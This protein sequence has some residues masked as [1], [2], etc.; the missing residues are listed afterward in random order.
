MQ[1]NKTRIVV[2]GMGAVTPL[3]VGVENFWQNLLAGKSGIGP[4]TRYDTTDMPA[5]MAAEIHDF[6]PTEHGIP[7][8]IA[9]R[10]A[11]VTQYAYAAVGEALA[12][13]GYEVDPMRTGIVLGTALTSTQD[14]AEG[15]NTFVA[16]GSKKASPHFVPKILPSIAACQVAIGFNLRG[17]N[18]TLSN[19]CASGDDAVGLAAML[20]R[21]GAADAIVA[22]G[23]EAVTCPVVVSSLAASRVLITGDDPTAC[24]PFDKD[25]AGFVLGE[26]GGALVLE[27][28][29]H[30]KARGAKI[31][32]VLL[33]H[34][35]NNDAFHITTP[36]DGGE[37]GADCIRLALEDAGL[38]PGDIDYINSHGTGTKLG[39][40]LECAAVRSVFGDELLKEIPMNSLRGATGHMMAAGSITDSI[41][42]LLAMRDG[43]IPPTLNFETPDPD[44]PIDCVPN[45]ARK[46]ELN[47]VMNNAFGFGGQNASLIFGKYH[48]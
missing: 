3:G 4:I 47:I 10:M 28:E 27:T 12:D 32:G 25:R 19:A 6:D 26:G 29:E 13:S 43:M 39:D 23:C 30:A 15:E 21:G 36:R 7:K 18:Y 8:K 48:D 1:A 14:I 42:C 2:T 35:N 16:H 31:Y 20:L 9:D 24:R 17:P 33:G 22:V 44:C 46:K 41:T 38:Q 40:A 11:L 34:G 37:G 45:V 5:H